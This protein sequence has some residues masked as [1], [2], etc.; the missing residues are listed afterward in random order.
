M[1]QV[2]MWQEDVQRI[3]LVV[4]TLFMARLALVHL[5]TAVGL[6]IVIL[7]IKLT[8]KTTPYMC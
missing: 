3:Q 5:T 4:K 8:L 6:T 2:Q 7:A 1:A